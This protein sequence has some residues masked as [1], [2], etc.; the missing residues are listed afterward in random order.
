MGTRGAC[1]A[2][3]ETLVCARSAGDRWA[4]RALLM[5][6]TR[7]SG[8]LSWV[9][10]SL[11]DRD[12]V[13]QSLRGRFGSGHAAGLLPARLGARRATPSACT[14][15]CGQRRFTPLSAEPLH[16]SRVS[17]R[18]RA[19]EKRYVTRNH[20]SV[21]SGARRRC[22]QTWCVRSAARLVRQRACTRKREAAR[23]MW[24]HSSVMSGVKRRCSQTWVRTK[25][26]TLR[27]PARGQRF[28]RMP[29]NSSS[30]LTLARSDH[31]QRM[32]W[33]PTTN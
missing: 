27:A 14:R 33:R 21:M 31:D 15:I 6:S 5:E 13:F 4:D 23:D 20:S 9:C 10:S 29:G 1:G 17:A 2:R 16:A 32:R 12:L 28:S 22:S 7:L 26:S 19:K 8:Q 25:C 18:A 11:P 30:S 24:N 3:L